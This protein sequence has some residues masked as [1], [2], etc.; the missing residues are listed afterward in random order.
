MRSAYVDHSI[1]YLV[2]GSADTRLY[3]VVKDEFTT[4]DRVAN[5]MVADQ[6]VVINKLDDPGRRWLPNCHSPG[7]TGNSKWSRDQ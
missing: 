2:D 7:A 1:F 6:R 4:V 5:V 3:V